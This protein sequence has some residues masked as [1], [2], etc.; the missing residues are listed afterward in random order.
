MLISSVQ[1]YRRGT[2]LRNSVRRSWNR[3][4]QLWFHRISQYRPILIIFELLLLRETLLYCMIATVAVHAVANS[5][6]LCNWSS[7]KDHLCLVCVHGVFHTFH[8]STCI[9]TL[10]CISCI[11]FT[12]T[13]TQHSNHSTIHQ[14]HPTGFII[15]S[16]QSCF[17][18]SVQSL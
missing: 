7:F 1:H 8:V 4:V 15:V 18:H 3:A 9:N 13:R 10:L 6:C 11:S 5:C 16:A 14:R 17:K 12:D 2:F